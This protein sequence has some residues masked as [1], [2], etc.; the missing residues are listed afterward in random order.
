MP[1]TTGTSL[2]RGI[3]VLLALAS[4]DA[5]AGGL[6]VTRIAALTGHEKSQISRTLKTLAELGLVDR[7]PS[8]LAYRLGW[9]LFALASHAGDQPL[10]AAASPLLDRLVSGLGEGAHLSVLQGTDVLTVLSKSSERAVRAVGWVGHTVPAYCTSSGRALLLDHSIEDLKVLWPGRRFDRAGP[11]SP[12]HLAELHER[13]EVARALGYSVADEELEQGL[14][15]VAAPVR[16]LRGRIV[17]AIDV[18]A[19]KFR[20]ADTVDHA[21]RKVRVAADELSHIVDWNTARGEGTA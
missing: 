11:R 6:G 2:R 4:D 16:D 18:S 20:L 8:T 9:Q 14:V 10:L 12:S 5:R 19:P 21:A 17:A 1:G 15:G 13:I 7:D 3:A